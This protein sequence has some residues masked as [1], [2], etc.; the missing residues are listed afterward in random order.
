[1]NTTIKYTNCPVCNSTAIGFKLSAA[2]HTVSK[3]LF[4]IWECAQCTL[5][6][7]QEVPDM[8]S[9]GSY[10]QSDNYISHSN[11]S[12]GIV[13]RLYHFIRKITLRQ[14]RSLLKASAGVT[15]G[16]LLDIGAG[17]GAFA[18]FMQQSGWQVTALEPDEKAR[19]IAAATNNI[20]LLSPEQLF[21]L[22]EN[23][24]DAITMWH[25]LE[26]VH[27]LHQYM[28]QLKKIIKLSGR[29][30]IAVPNYTSYDAQFY[31][32]HWAAYDVPRHL[33]HFSPQAMKQLLHKNGLKLV[34]IRPM[35][36]DSFY[37]SLL[38][39]KYK[40]G[41]GG[42]LK[43]AWRGLQSNGKAMFQKERCSS[44]IYIICR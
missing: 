25:V 42:L 22:P 40:S 7:T 1:M 4:E 27:S 35:W 6:F 30:F 38:S 44:V 14:K 10:Y 20:S 28:Q 26:H 12:K 24:Y 11:T 39:E 41:K 34:A 2:D 8:G 5:Q 3:Q 32:S 9:I 33:Y 43:G 31:K 13:N 15:T 18:A 21:Q 17:T 16:S 37:V 29:L 23:T 19:T 36:F